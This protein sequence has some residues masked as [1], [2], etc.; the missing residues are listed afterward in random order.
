MDDTHP[1]IKDEFHRRLM[2]HSGETRM[3]M[4]SRMFDACREMVLASVPNSLS[5]SEI[6]EALFLRFY[7]DEFDEK[8]RIRILEYLKSR[9]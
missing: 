1:S 8:H 4:G 6:R 5:D 7:G 9:G 3:V 2:A